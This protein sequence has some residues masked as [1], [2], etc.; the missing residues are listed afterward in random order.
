MDP[1]PLIGIAEAPIPD[2]G[3]AFWLTA[4][5]GVRLR[6][7][8]FAAKGAAKGSVVLSPGRTE[9]IEKYFEVIGEL[10][11]RGFVVLAH[12]WRGQG[13]SDRALPDRLRGH[14]RGFSPFLADY[15]LML[16]LLQNDLP[17]P[18]VSLAHSMGGGLVLLALAMGEGRLAGLISTAPMI[19]LYSVRVLPAAAAWIARAAVLCGLGG[20]TVQ[21][22]D[23]FSQPFEGNVLTHD[24]ARYDR[25]MAQ[26]RACP[27]LALGGPTWGWLEFALSAGAR[28]SR[29]GCAQSLNLP[30]SFVAAGQDRL[31]LSAAQ[32]RF[33]EAAPQG[34][35]EE[36]AGSYHEILM[37]TDAVRAQFWR[38]FDAFV[39]R[40]RRPSA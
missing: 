33:A 20:V 23:P 39:G 22:Y 38:A 34:V 3:R 40:V 36:I 2:N 31:V 18:C 7:A 15:V 21:G 17:K 14:A 13:L 9:P 8:L 28:L 32:R 16:D 29:P 19:G 24:K 35:F 27:D 25:Y 12:D 26:L 37:E 4:R 30:I 6:A 5:D 11:G 1:A 10:Q